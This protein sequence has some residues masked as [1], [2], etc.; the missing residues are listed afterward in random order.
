KGP[1]GCLIALGILG[2]LVVLGIA[3]IAFGLWR[4]S[5]SEDGKKFVDGVQKGYAAS[6]E[7]QAAPGTNELRTLGCN[8]AAVFDNEKLSKTWSY[9]DG[10]LKSSS[11]RDLRRTVVCGTSFTTDP[12]P[13]DQ[14]AATYV[15]AVGPVAEGFVVMTSKAG[16]T[17][18]ICQA[19]FA[20]DG[21]PVPTAAPTDEAP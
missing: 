20:P 8:T 17:T 4:F 3:V 5:K 19:S 14:V 7:A 1:S 21:T 12:P 18:P 9:G 16:H 10:G 11:Q 15:R 6:V 2:A 13:C